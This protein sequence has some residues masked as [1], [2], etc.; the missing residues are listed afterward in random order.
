VTRLATWTAGNSAD[1]AAI[2]FLLDALGI[3][4]RPVGMPAE[5][6]DGPLL[7]HGPVE[8]AAGRVVIPHR[9]DDAR[10]PTAALVHRLEVDDAPEAVLPFDV[11]SVIGSL[12]RDEADGTIGAEGR[13][14]H[15][16]VRYAASTAA[17]TGAG[18]PLVDGLIERTGWWLQRYLGMRGVDRWPDGARFAVG[19][20]HDV[21]HPDRY[22]TLRALAG[23][24]QRL[25][26]A[27][28]TLAIRT[29]GDVAAMLRRPRPGSFWVFDRLIESEASRG[30]AATWFFAA[31]PFHAGWGTTYDVA[32]DITERRFRH[33]FDRLA[34]AGH[35]VGLHTGYDAHAAPGRIAAERERLVRASGA[36]VDGNRHHYWHLG[37][38]PAAT[39]RAHDAAGFRYDSSI[40]FNDHLGFRRS[41]S[42]PFHPFDTPSNRPL[43]LRELPVFAM[44][45]NLFYR[46]NDVERAVAT[47]SDGLDDIADLRGLAIFDWHLQACVPTHS[48]YDPWAE[49][50]Q[51]VLDLLAART[52]VWV[53]DLGSIDR[54]WSERRERVEAA[55]ADGAN[56]TG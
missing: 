36:P 2:A 14:E 10:S 56:A 24:P 15:G 55:G 42:L 53:T 20:S 40:A 30:F 38:D 41:T 51:A 34:E 26:A 45:G 49:A 46:S 3:A 16:R 43:R 9:P 4:E 29:V 25:R 28:R 7:A 1:R 39:L 48:A 18:G 52:D 21:D 17:G 54:W 5:G 35:E 31:S 37:P 12:L 13:D 6:G 33:V 32:Y 23:A 22:P 47:I 8:P 27:P 19:L 44:D 11:V 50:Y